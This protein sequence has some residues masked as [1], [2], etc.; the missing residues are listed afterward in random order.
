MAHDQTFVDDDVS[1]GR[2]LVHETQSRVSCA[3]AVPNLFRTPDLSYCSVCG[4][5]KRV[6]CINAAQYAWVKFKEKAGRWF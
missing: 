6:G 1:C 3:T 4:P 2:Y 5:Q